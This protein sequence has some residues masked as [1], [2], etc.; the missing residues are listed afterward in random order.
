MQATASQFTGLFP[1][2]AEEQPEA[3]YQYNL[4]TITDFYMSKISK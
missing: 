1:A 2:E 4:L 3:A